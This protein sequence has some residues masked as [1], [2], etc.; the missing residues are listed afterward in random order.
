M[1]AFKKG[2]KVTQVVRTPIT[3]TILAFGLDEGREATDTDVG[4]TP[5]ITVKVGWIETELVGDPPKE[6]EEDG[7]TKVLHPHSRWFRLDEIEA[8]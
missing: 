2:D 6:G 4:E 3:G 8:A 5:S 1:T 7:R